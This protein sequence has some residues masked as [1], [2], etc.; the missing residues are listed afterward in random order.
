LVIY[1]VLY[2]QMY[3]NA[4]IKTPSL[5]GENHKDSNEAIL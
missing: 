5:K 3:Y 4:E 2:S 1:C